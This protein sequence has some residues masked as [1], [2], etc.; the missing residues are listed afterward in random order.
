[1]I[2]KVKNDMNKWYINLKSWNNKTP[3]ASYTEPLAFINNKIIKV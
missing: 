1:M 2:V 3:N